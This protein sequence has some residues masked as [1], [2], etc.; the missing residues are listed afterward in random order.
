MKSH[1]KL[2]AAILLLVP[3]LARPQTAPKFPSKIRAVTAKLFYLASGTFSEDILNKPNIALWNTVIGE[4][5]SGGASEATLVIVEV[6]GDGGPMTLHK[7]VLSITTQIDGKPPVKRIVRR[8]L[9]EKSG[10]HFEG[11]WLYDTGCL[12]VQITAQLDNQKPLSK[13]IS[14]QCGE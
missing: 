2:G 11:V 6:D 8:M 3:T 9:F 12:P 14:F 7:E 4:G 5:E 10:K 13:K 1:W